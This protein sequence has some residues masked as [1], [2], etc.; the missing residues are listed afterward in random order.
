MSMV[1]LKIQTNIYPEKIAE[2]E[3]AMKHLLHKDDPKKQNYI[4]GF[5]KDW[6]NPNAFFYLEEWESE[7]KL[8]SHMESDSFKAFIGAMKVLGE[9]E[10]A[11]IIHAS[12]IDDL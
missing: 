7:A 3:Q 5:Y 6:N 12:Q 11:K 1:F 9:I 10:N 2:F 4:K 8:K